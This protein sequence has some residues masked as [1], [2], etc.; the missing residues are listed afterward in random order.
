VVTPV[1]ADAR[2]ARSAAAERFERIITRA[3]HLTG[4]RAARL[5]LL[6]GVPL[7]SRVYLAQ[8]LAQFAMASGGGAFLSGMLSRLQL[9][10]TAFRHLAFRT[11]LAMGDLDAAR[12][13]AAQAGDDEWESRETQQQLGATRLLAGGDATGALQVLGPQIAGSSAPHYVAALRAAG[14]PDDVLAAVTAHHAELS[15][16]ETA[17]AR[18]DAHWQLGRADR[19]RQA[20]ED[21]AGGQLGN[22]ELISRLR[23]G[24]VATGSTSEHAYD[25]VLEIADAQPRRSEVDWRIGLD[26]TFNRVDHILNQASPGF[27]AR[28]QPRGRYTLAAAAYVRRDFEE[29]RRQLRTLLGTA[30]HWD[31]EKLHARMLLEEGHFVEALDNR[32]VRSR[33]RPA[34]D[35]IEYFARLHLGQHRHAFRMYL[36]RR[37]AHRL[38]AT[39]GEAADLLPID[40]VGT[41]FVIPQDGP[42]D[43][44]SMSATYPQLL[45]VSD[46]VI[47]ACDPR[48]TSLLRRSFPEVEFVPTYRQPSRPALGFLAA[49][50]PPRATG[51]MY[52]LLSAEAASHAAGADRVVLG[53]SLVR[54]TPGAAPYEP[55]IRPDPLLV[56][57]FRRDRATVGVVWRSEFVDPMRS[58]HFL[59]PSDLAPIAELDVDVLC[60]QHDATPAER[61]A[62][63]AAF[64]DRAVF[65]DDLDLRDDFEAIAAVTA[66]CSAVAGV[67]TTTTELAAAVGTRTIYLHPNLIG[68]WRRGDQG[69]DY[70]HRTMRAAVA[71]DYRSPDACVRHLVEMLRTMD[72][73]AP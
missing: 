39:F 5:L 28:L 34:L 18:F 45:A 36:A 54:L 2:L 73:S 58:I 63:I 9:A 11:Y 22:V 64:G 21:L 55:Y 67:G 14:R 53:R 56:E 72:S 37:D 27:V 62:L 6:P 25:R 52:D 7:G 26:F 4:A 23:S 47:A 16:T 71:D 24:Y 13:A 51:N 32:A 70:W 17:L 44:I 1:A 40:E 8:R 42:G 46:R 48:L 3:S 68:A 43:E 66:A 12:L 15:P 30:H 38:R 49:D 19:A 33:L 65:L 59:R 69:R 57:R 35:E 60:L 10:D 31:A 29:S 50:R 41:R 20:V 61:S